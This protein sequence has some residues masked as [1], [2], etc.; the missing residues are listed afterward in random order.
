MLPRFPTALKPIQYSPYIKLHYSGKSVFAFYKIV[1]QSG[2]S[3]GLITENTLLFIIKGRKEIHLEDE[4]L[5]VGPN[6]LAL[7]KRGSYFMSNIL[8]NDFQGLMLAIDD[9]LLR[10]FLTEDLESGIP[11][12]TIPVPMVIPCSDNILQIRSSILQFMEHP[13]EYT[14]RLLELKLREL[15]L[16][17]LSGEYR[18]QVIAYLHHMFANPSEHLQMTIKANLLKPLSLDDYAR[19]CGMSLS[20]FKREFTRIYKESPKKWI[21]DEK[22]KHADYLLKNTS[23]NINEIS[24]TCGFEQP[25]YFIRC[26]KAY[27]GETPNTTRRTRIATF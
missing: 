2:R 6:H 12:T 15:L 11:D 19:L 17:L 20:T 21:N 7:L 23:S 1:E 8:E 3:E 14:S 9:K 24:D 26:Y 4:D 13:N 16:T 10:S 5:V 25:S 27:F 18:H 22:L